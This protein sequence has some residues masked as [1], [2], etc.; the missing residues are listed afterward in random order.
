[1]RITYHTEVDAWY[2]P[3]C[4]GESVENREPLPGVILDIGKGGAL[5]GIEVLNASRRC[6]LKELAHV[7]TTLP[8]QIAES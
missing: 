8:L 1:M 2:I 4:D 3:I 7:D 5:L 6:P